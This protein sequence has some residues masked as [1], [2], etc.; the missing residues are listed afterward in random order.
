MF[1]SI[2]NKKKNIL[3]VIPIYLNTLFNLFV[4]HLSF[5]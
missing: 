4:E 1:G 5:D 2:L 3:I